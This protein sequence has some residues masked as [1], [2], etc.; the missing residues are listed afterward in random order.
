MYARLKYLIGF[1]LLPLLIVACGGGGEKKALPPAKHPSESANVTPEDPMKNWEDNKGIGPVKSVT[2]G[3]IDPAMA[4][5]GKAIYEELCTACHK[6]DK[7]FIGPAPKGLLDRRTPEWAMNMILNPEEM[8]EKDP[9]AKQLLVE[10]NGAPMANQ[11]LTE[12]QARKVLEYIR[13]L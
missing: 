10:A 4:E 7:K 12:D 1:M 2:L 11:N 13:T 6:P 5:E 8:I 9:I 3:E